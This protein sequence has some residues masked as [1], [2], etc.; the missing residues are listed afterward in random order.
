[1]T[2]VAPATTKP[3]KPLKHETTHMSKKNYLKKKLPDMSKLA[4]LSDMPVTPAAP[5][6]RSIR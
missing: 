1:M 3:V 2:T 6:N 5:T 4:K